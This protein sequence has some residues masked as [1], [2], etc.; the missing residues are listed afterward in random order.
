M[1]RSIPVLVMGACALTTTTKALAAEGWAEAPD[2]RPLVVANEEPRDEE[3]RP[4]TFGYKSDSAVRVSVGSAARADSDALRAGLFAAIDFG[5]G[6]AGFRASA[7]W[8]RVGYDDPLAQY[9]GE[10]TLTIGEFSRFIPSL[11]AGGGLARTYRVDG[12]GARTDGGANLGVG[13]LR[14]ELD[15]RLPFGETD[16][17]AG[18][19]ASGVMP[20][21]RA[22]D[23]PDLGPWMIFTGTVTIGF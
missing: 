20:A 16:A 12:A 2:R 6:P 3:P 22:S 21:V 10:L 1:K 19:S 4:P 9:T 11:G 17:R 5:K 18:L 8:V 7:A 13:V 14:A 15:Y 23:A